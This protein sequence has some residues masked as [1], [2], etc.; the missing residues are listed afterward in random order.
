MLNATARS[1]TITTLI[2]GY[3]PIQ[4]KTSNKKQ[5]PVRNEKENSKGALRVK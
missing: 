4:N 1:E 5:G 2:I 3:T